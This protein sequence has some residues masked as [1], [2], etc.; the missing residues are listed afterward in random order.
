MS[1]T[2]FR[3]GEHV[4][5][6]NNGI[7]RIEDIRILAFGDT[8]KEYYVLAPLSGGTVYVPTEGAL[9]LKLKRVPTKEDVDDLI[10]QVEAS[11]LKWIEN[12]KLRIV[13][14]DK[15]LASSDRVAILWLVKVLSARKESEAE[16]NK[17]LCS[18]EERI[19]TTAE[20]II[21]EEFAFALNL[22]KNEVVPY[23]LS[24]ISKA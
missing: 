1:E 14:F 12:S 4:I 6:K 15:L 3:T 20:K 16:K 22:N 18:N 24:K 2:Q 11:E 8:K 13:T 21:T 19:L 17:R 5:Y 7:C 10:A 9:A 23:I